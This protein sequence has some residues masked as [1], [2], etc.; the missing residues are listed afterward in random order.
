MNRIALSA[1]I[2]TALE[3]Y[4]FFLFGTASAIVFN[5]L[6]FVNEDPAVAA[7]ASFATFGVGFLARPLGAVLFGKMGDKYG[8]RPALILSIV[9]IGLATGFV[10]LLPDYF[11]I[12]MAAPILLTLLRLFQGVA[13]G[14]EW[15]GATA[16]AIEH[17]PAEKRGRYAALIQIGSPAGTLLSSGAFSLAFML[18]SESFDAWGWR[19]PFLAA[20]PFLV[21]AL[22][23]RL[24]VEESPVF[25][26]LE[27][28]VDHDKEEQGSLRALFSTHGK[29]I[30]V[31]AAAAIT[32]IGGFFVMNTYA[33]SYGSNVLGIDR[34]DMVTATMFAAVVQVFI[35]L[36]FGRFAEKVGASKVVVL[37]GIV[38]AVL[39][40]PLWLLI[41]TGNVIA[42][43]IAIIIG[44][45]SVT[46]PYSVIGVLLGALFP[47]QVRYSGMAIAFNIAGAI[48]GLL[49]FLA[50]WMN[51]FYEEQSVIPAVIILALIS[52]VTAIGGFVGDKMADKEGEF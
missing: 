49:P 17:A 33:L 20:F 27:E 9:V 34:Q 8:R 5:H 1:F 29:Q 4:D 13:V 37:G 16:L 43:G 10:G 32:G 51:S 47:A 24:H 44:L 28:E 41:N 2:G 50:T 11:A 23:I 7:L 14:G 52:I 38:T 22:L 25:K 21:I 40:L 42:M 19:L 12:G 6:F 30:I 18:P 45:A 48:S 46:V 31:G 15:G 36:F 26:A 39:A 3:W 35:N